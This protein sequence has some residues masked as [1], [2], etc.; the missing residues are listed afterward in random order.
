MKSYYKKQ[1]TSIELKEKMKIFY[2]FIFCRIYT[3]VLLDGMNFRPAVQMRFQNFNIHIIF[4]SYLL[5]FKRTK[6][7]KK[8]HNWN[9][10]KK[11]ECLHKYQMMK[12]YEEENR[13]RVNQ[14]D[15]TIFQLD[16]LFLLLTGN[17]K[18]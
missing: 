8:N 5:I 6:N 3:F 13:Q 12:I 1:P 17:M 16:C 11:S 9:V 4:P 15:K 18:L 10:H 7:K 2:H 14:F